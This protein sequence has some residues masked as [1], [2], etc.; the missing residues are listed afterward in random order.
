MKIEGLGDVV[1]L[2]TKTTGIK[3]VV[4]IISEAID[5]DC[6]CDQR[7]DDLNKKLPLRPRRIS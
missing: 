1:E 7:R 5:K 2:V 4:K 6:G 3:K